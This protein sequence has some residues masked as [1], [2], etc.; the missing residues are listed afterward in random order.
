MLSGKVLFAKI[1]NVHNVLRKLPSIQHL[2]RCHGALHGFKFD[3]NKTLGGRA[4]SFFDTRHDHAEHLAVLQALQSHVFFD[5]DVLSFVV[6]VLTRHHVAQAQHP[7]RRNASHLRCLRWRHKSSC[8]RSVYA[9]ARGHA[10]QSTKELLLLLGRT[11]RSGRSSLCG[12]THTERLL[13]QGH[14][15]QSRNRCLRVGR[16]HILAEAITLGSDGAWVAH[17]VERFNRTKC[18]HQLHNLLV[19]EIVGQSSD[20]HLART[21]LRR[22]S[23]SSNSG[24][25][26][27][28]CE[29]QCRDRAEVRRK[30]FGSVIVRATHPDNRRAGVVFKLDAIQLHRSGSQLDGTKLHKGVTLLHVEVNLDHRRSLR[31]CRMQC[32]GHHVVEEVGD[33]NLRSTRRNAACVDA[34]CVAGQHRS[35]IGIHLWLLVRRRTVLRSCCAAARQWG[36]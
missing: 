32:A 7:C 23:T 30:H 3:E 15:V 36:A 12:Q 1:C 8:S 18:T 11:R 2:R 9:H 33:F 10:T 22:T 31:A 20:E 6:Q 34:T 16:I 5:V 17:L 25:N 28:A 35:R 26:A 13:S 29:V 21:S 19:R 27:E 4:V 14:A 24:R